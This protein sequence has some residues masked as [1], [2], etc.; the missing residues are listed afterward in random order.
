MDYAE[1]LANA[2][3]NIGPNCKVCP[4]CNGLACANTMPGP[5]SKAPGNGAN[6]NWKA[7]RGI[8][9]NMDTIY[10]DAPVDTGIELFGKSLLSAADL[11]A[12]RLAQ[13]AVQP[14]GR[15]PRL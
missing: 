5:G 1:V 4:E 14:H 3:K 8:K 12:G 2:K 11:R 15:Y 6:D 13:G 9:L 10:P 7:W